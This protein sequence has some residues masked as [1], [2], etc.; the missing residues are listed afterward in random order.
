M[1]ILSRSGSRSGP[2]P[3]GL[4]AVS[5]S[6]FLIQNVEAFTEYFGCGLE[7]CC[8][9]PR[10]PEQQPRPRGRRSIVR[11]DW[12][13][14]QTQLNPNLYQPVQLWIVQV[15]KPDD[16]VHAGLTI[17]NLDALAGVPAQA[18]E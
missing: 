10:I 2:L 14:A 9:Q 7:R 1:A 15:A 12:I 5:R 6:G 3:S 17:V 11:V 18:L 13:E 16:H 8:R 4:A